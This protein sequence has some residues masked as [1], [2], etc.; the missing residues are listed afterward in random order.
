MNSHSLR[1]WGAAAYRDG[2]PDDWAGVEL[3]L[4]IVLTPEEVEQVA[5]EVVQHVGL[6][7]F[8]HRV[9]I[10]GSMREL[11]TKPLE[12]GGVRNDTDSRPLFR[13]WSLELS[14]Q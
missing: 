13:C 10:D 6:V 2:L 12:G 7:A 9:D 3:P 4:Q 11:Q 5:E 1:P 14:V 8:P